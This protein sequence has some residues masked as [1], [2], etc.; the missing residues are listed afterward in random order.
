MSTIRLNNLL[1]RLIKNKIIG[2]CVDN[3]ARK[4]NIKVN[5]K[6]YIIWFVINFA[7]ME[8]TSHVCKNGNVENVV[9]PNCSFFFY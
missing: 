5:K 6:K 9:I 3:E 7:G 4:I 2:V 1:I 8:C